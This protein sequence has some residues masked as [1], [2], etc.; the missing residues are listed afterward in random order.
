VHQDKERMLVMRHGDKVDIHQ[1]LAKPGNVLAAGQD[2]YVRFVVYRV[3]AAIFQHLGKA[4]LGLRI[5][6]LELS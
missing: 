2:H 5:P 1:P 4:H 3:R 6:L